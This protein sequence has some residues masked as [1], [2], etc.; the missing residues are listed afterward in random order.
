MAPALRKIG[1]YERRPVWTSGVQYLNLCASLLVRDE[2]RGLHPTHLPRLQYNVSISDSCTL[3][4]IQ[5]RQMILPKAQ[6]EC[7]ETIR[8]SRGRVEQKPSEPYCGFKNLSQSF[9]TS[10]KTMKVGRSR[11]CPCQHSACPP[12]TPE[13]I[14]YSTKKDAVEFAILCSVSSCGNYRSMRAKNMKRSASSDG[15]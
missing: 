10:Y 1:Q 5:F 8:A 3:R 14:F 11:G 13:A 15:I 9:S 4:G 6:L 7:D 2:S 12:P